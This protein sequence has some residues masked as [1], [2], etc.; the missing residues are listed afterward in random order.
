M[1]STSTLIGREVENRR[2]FWKTRL[3]GKITKLNIEKLPFLMFCLLLI[4][5]DR[6][7]TSLTKTQQ[8]L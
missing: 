5:K 2:V 4:N 8:K 3:N 6:V 7:H 1:V